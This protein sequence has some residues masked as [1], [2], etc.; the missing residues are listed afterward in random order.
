HSGMDMLA[1]GFD[2]SSACTLT[3]TSD[4]SPFGTFSDPPTYM[5]WLKV[6]V[7]SPSILLGSYTNVATCQ[8][9]MFAPGLL[10]WTPVKDQGLVYGD[11]TFFDPATG[12]AQDV[13]LRFASFTGGA[14]PA[15]GTVIQE[16]ANPTFALTLPYV[17]AVVYTV[18][19]GGNTDGIY[20][21]GDLPFP[22]TTLP[23]PP[24]QH[25][26]AGVGGT[27]PDGGGD[28]SDGG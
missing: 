7:T 15:S 27:N 28:A 9:Q 5:F 23:T 20:L 3:T 8:S 11:E 13:T 18:N 25:P 26:D 2:F 6:D 21:R 10:V 17:S 4:G 1:N 24:L 14:L 22:A 19:A 16:R 12:T